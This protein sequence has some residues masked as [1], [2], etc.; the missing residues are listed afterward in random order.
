MY[1]QFEGNTGMYILEALV[2]MHTCTQNYRPGEI[3]N[4]TTDRAWVDDNL[5]MHLLKGRRYVHD[6]T[7]L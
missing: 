3:V 2:D 6:E 7:S 5:D 1:T 4:N